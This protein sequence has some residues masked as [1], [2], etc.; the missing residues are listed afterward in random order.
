MGTERNLNNLQEQVTKMRK[1]KD[2]SKK[3][4]N[5]WKQVES[6]ALEV[7][8]SK[9]VCQKLDEGTGEVILTSYPW[10]GGDIIGDLDGL[11]IGDLDGDPIYVLVEA[12]HN[13]DSGGRKAKTQLKN[14]SDYFDNYLF[15]ER[16]DLDDQEQENVNE[17]RDAVKINKLKGRTR[18]WAFGGVQCKYPDKLW[19]KGKGCFMV[20]PNHEMQYEV[21]RIEKHDPTSPSITSISN[22]KHTQHT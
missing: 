11:V 12:K 18:Y 5:G 16:T 17:D 10:K 9:A 13:L 6:D 2:E 20:Q 15:L 19:M 8:V 1:S 3:E 21:V 14:S 7:K 4:W 22:H